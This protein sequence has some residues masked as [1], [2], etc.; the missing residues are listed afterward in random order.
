M[1]I[2]VEMPSTHRSPPPPFGSLTTLSRFFNELFILSIQ[3]L[4]FTPITP[5]LANADWLASSYDTPAVTFT[6]VNGTTTSFGYSPVG[7]VCDAPKRE[8]G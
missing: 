2:V 3:V 5:A 6:D 7:K 8:G 4:P 1:L